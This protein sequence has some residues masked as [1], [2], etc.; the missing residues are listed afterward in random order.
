M[1]AQPP[2]ACS[3]H[4]TTKAAPNPTTTA[5]ARTLTNKAS[6]APTD[7]HRAS[8]DLLKD[9]TDLPKEDTTASRCS[10]SRA[11]RP[12]AATTRTTG[13]LMAVVAV[14]LRDCAL[15]WRA[16]AAW[17]ACSRRVVETSKAGWDDGDGTRKRWHTRWSSLAF[18]PPEMRI[19]CEDGSR[20]RGIRVQAIDRGFFCSHW[21]LSGYD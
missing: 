7:R 10:T 13:G 20:R 17:T 11:H 2:A 9:N 3:P 4:T 12:Q 15:V 18:W 1:L 14:Y 21:G 19:S 5:A 8:T 16:V 6:L